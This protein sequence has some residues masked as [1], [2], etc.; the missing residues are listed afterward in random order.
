MRVIYI[1]LLMLFLAADDSD[2]RSHVST[3]M[4]DR[5]ASKDELEKLVTTVPRNPVSKMK[6]VNIYSWSREYVG[7]WIFQGST[8]KTECNESPCP[9]TILFFRGGGEHDSA[10]VM[11]NSRFALLTSH[12][13]RVTGEVITVVFENENRPL[14][15]AITPS[16]IVIYLH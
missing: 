9:T 13:P 15:A 7:L 11:A 2:A 14:R 1:V 5:A 16:G 12:F 4:I 10:S 3:H 6:F 8:K